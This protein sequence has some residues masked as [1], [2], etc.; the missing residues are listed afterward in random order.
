MLASRRVRSKPLTGSTITPGV[1]VGTRKR[2]GPP[3][4]RAATTTTSAVSPSRTQPA[5]PSSRQPPL[6][7][8]AVTSSRSGASRPVDPV[9][10]TAPVVSPIAKPGNHCCC[11]SGVPPSTIAVV[12]STALDTNAP[13]VRC[14]PSSLAINAA[15][16]MPASA[17]PCS[18]GT[19]RLAQPSSAISAHNGAAA[20]P[21]SSSNART[22]SELDRSS[23]NDCAASRSASLSSRVSVVMR[24]WAPVAVRGC[25]PR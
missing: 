16:T 1:A 5:L 20:E 13:G 4:V 7:A 18:S 12:A 6:S 9:K 15:A 14:A 23:R 21:G 25:A 3:S 10:A 17:P 8:V 11:C 19:S 22:A 2:H 24:S